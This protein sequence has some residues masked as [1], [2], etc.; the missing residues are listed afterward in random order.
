MRLE[1]ISQVVRTLDKYPSEDEAKIFC[2]ENDAPQL[3]AEASDLRP[4]AFWDYRVKDLD[5]GCRV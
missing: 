2:D 3:E 1:L 4:V 5:L